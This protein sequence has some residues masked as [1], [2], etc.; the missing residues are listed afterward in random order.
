MST[1]PGGDCT[2]NGSVSERVWSL[3][4]GTTRTDV[5]VVVDDGGNI[6]DHQVEDIRDVVLV[7]VKVRFVVALVVVVVLLGM[8]DTDASG[9]DSTGDGVVFASTIGIST[10]VRI[11]LVVSSTV[12]RFGTAVVGGNNTICCKS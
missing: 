7:E 5:L 2:S 12:V 4:G 6:R 11:V 3:F 1:T 10:S 9:S 8:V